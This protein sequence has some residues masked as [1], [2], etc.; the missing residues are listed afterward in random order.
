MLSSLASLF[1][2]LHEI[3][4]SIIPLVYEILLSLVYYNVD[5]MTARLTTSNSGCLSTFRR[6]EVDSERH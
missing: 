6:F 3:E 1:V 2:V 4:S 5:G